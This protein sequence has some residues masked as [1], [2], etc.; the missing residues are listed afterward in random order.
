MPETIGCCVM[1]FLALLGVGCL[2]RCLCLL[3][4]RPTRDMPCFSVAY[5]RKNDENA[6]Q[7][8]RFFRMRAR[9]GEKLLLVD[10]G[11]D[12]TQR[13]I[14]E[15]LCADGTDVQFLTAEN[16]VAENCN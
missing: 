5:L 3:I 1:L 9:R 7:I 12:G 11:A 13:E 4:L 14:A 8:V 16:F 6:E 10:N 2:L 15:K